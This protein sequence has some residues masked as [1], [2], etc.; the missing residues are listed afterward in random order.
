[1]DDYSTVDLPADMPKGIF[2]ILK[3]ARVAGK[4]LNI[5]SYKGETDG[6]EKDYSN[7]P[8]PKQYKPSKKSYNT[9]RDRGEGPKAK[10][11]FALKKRKDRKKP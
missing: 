10:S 6:T 4:P 8:K 7:H 5:S 11:D 1:M 2:S 9:K 3:K